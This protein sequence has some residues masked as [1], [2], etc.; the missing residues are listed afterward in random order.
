MRIR[1]MQQQQDEALQVRAS[2]QVA[3]GPV[4][5]RTSV[6]I[7]STR[8]DSASKEKRLTRRWNF[9]LNLTWCRRRRRNRL[10]NPKRTG[11]LAGGN[12]VEDSTERQ[13]TT[14]CSAANKR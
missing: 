7:N 4:Q 8:L 2:S 14:C 5:F 9:R 3:F 13:K 11:E 1:K 6:R 10:K 12:Q